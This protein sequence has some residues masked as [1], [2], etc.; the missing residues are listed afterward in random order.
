MTVAEPTQFTQSTAPVSAPPIAPPPP[1][2][3]DFIASNS[4]ERQIVDILGAADPLDATDFDPIE[5]IN[6]IFPSGT[7]H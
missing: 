2:V 6:S 3:S 5:H 1:P 4:L 7:I